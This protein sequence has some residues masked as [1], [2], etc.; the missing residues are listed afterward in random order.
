MESA[1]HRLGHSFSFPWFD[2][3][4]RYLYP[5]D[6]AGIASGSREGIWRLGRDTEETLGKHF[7]FSS[8]GSFGTGSGGDTTVAFVYLSRYSF[9]S[10]A[11]GLL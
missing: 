4:A 5:S 10:R 1:S 7:P 8:L 6:M 9:T 11:N 2:P 3:F